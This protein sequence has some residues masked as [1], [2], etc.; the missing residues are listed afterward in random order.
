MDS[1]SADIYQF[2]ANDA[3]ADST[4]SRN[5]VEGISSIFFNTA[6][7]QPIV[8]SANLRNKITGIT[9]I[10]AFELTQIATQTDNSSLPFK[11]QTADTVF[12]GLGGS[13]SRSK[14]RPNFGQ[15]LPAPQ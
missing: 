5:S 14:S 10:K 8:E 9:H 4:S 7:L 1:S 12:V 11:F 15:I 13:G 6:I 3:I 2:Q